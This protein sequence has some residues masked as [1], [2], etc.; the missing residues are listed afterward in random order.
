VASD[1]DPDVLTEYEAGLLSDDAL[2][3][4]FAYLA[5]RSKLECSTPGAGRKASESFRVA[6]KE[7]QRRQSGAPPPTGL[8]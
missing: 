8:A 1:P 4:R 6:W 3:E 2:M 5:G 7:Y